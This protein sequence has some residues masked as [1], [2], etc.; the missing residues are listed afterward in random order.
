MK[1]INNWSS[2]ITSENNNLPNDNQ[3]FFELFIKGLKITKT[4]LETQFKEFEESNELHFEEYWAD[5]EIW[6]MEW[7][8]FITI[9]K[10]TWNSSIGY[11]W[12]YKVSFV[13]TE[14]VD[15]KNYDQIEIY[16]CIF[17]I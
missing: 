1:K 10:D 4:A 17:I 2:E 7:E 6:K 13:L 5:E 16:E 3:E 9:W 14:I 11:K 15:I 8:Q 12:K